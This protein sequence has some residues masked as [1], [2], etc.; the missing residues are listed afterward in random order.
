MLGI[1]RKQ[2]FEMSL[3]YAIVKDERET[4]SKAGDWSKWY[5]RCTTFIDPCAEKTYD[6]KKASSVSER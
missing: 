3:S 1:N 2:A 4:I 6:R 5:N